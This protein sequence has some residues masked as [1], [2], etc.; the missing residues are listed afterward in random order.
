MPRYRYECKN[1]GDLVIVF[2]GFKETFS[3]CEK[4]E[5]KDT[6][7]KLLSTPLTIK[8]PATKTSPTKIGELTKEYIE[9]NR[10]VL[11]QQKEEAKK[12]SNDAS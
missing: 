8:K 11:K 9:E 10:K 3:D 7:Q 6:M 12:K 1:C 2:H 5:Q 4:C